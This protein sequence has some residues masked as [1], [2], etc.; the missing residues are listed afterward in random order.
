MVKI[1]KFVD[2]IAVLDEKDTDTF[3]K[4]RESRKFNIKIGTVPPK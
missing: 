3:K 4:N 2:K 1:T